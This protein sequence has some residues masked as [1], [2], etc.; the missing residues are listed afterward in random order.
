MRGEYLQEV[1][2]VGFHLELQKS[3]SAYTEKIGEG[4]NNFKKAKN[5]KALLPILDKLKKCEALDPERVEE[6]TLQEVLSISEEEFFLLYQV[7]GEAIDKENYSSAGSMYTLLCL[8]NPTA[9][10]NW[11]GLGMAE[12]SQGNLEEGREVYHLA[13]ALDE[14]NPSI[15]L[16]AAECSFSLGE[17][18]EALSLTETAL[19]NAEEDLELL[20]IAKSMKQEILL[21]KA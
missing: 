20:D 3:F 12:V 2:G 7:A 10:L 21:K 15:N 19:K 14:E 5:K 13:L 17:Y 4:V 1:P 18:N 8:L 16:Y 6:K 11:L 9:S